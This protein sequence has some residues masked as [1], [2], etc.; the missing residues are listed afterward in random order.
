MATG[1]ACQTVETKPFDGQK[2][3]TSGLRK[4]VW[5]CFVVETLSVNNLTSEDGAGESNMRFQSHVSVS[6]S[7]F[8]VV[9]PQIQLDHDDESIPGESFLGGALSREFRAVRLRR[10][11]RNRT[12][13]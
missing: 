7:G 9:V 6:F 5:N 12:R 13:R 3:G 8:F 4:K 1:I 10:S 2:P 11:P